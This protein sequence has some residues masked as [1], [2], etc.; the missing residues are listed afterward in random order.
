V[1]AEKSIKSAAAP[2][3]K[4]IPEMDDK[5]TALV[6]ELRSQGLPPKAIAHRLGLRPAEVSVLIRQQAAQLEAS[7]DAA[8]LPAIR[9]CYLSPGF[10]T[11]LEFSGPAAAWRE[12]DPGYSGCD[13]MFCAMWVRAHRYDRLTACGALV[14]AYCLGVK[15]AWPPKN[16]HADEL[17]A[18]VSR[19]FRSYDAPPIE[20]PFELLQS[21]VLGA[22]DYAA[23]LGFEP[24]PDF[25]TV[26]PSLG[27]RNGSS[28]IRFGRDG[29]PVYVQGPDDDVF[30]I[31]QT[32]R[33]TVGD[34][35]FD[36]LTGISTS[37]LALTS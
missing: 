34:G 26:R 3:E 4:G 14:D 12:Y 13:G 23:S 5:T 32:L 10:S 24:H 7:G 35:G 17:R 11:G 20:V 29:R 15:N 36:C 2:E 8:A 6:A 27:T 21:L 16:L 9:V 28:P 22:V 31:V 1:A 18:Y 33:R 25:A 19:Y 37:P 30:R